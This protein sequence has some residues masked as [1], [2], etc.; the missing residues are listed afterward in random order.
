MAT[1]LTFITSIWS[2]LEPTLLLVQLGFQF[3]TKRHLRV[4]YSNLEPFV[5]KA[6]INTKNHIAHF[7]IDVDKAVPADFD[8]YLKHIKS[9]LKTDRE[10]FIYFD[11]EIE[12]RLLKK[13]RISNENRF[14]KFIQKSYLYLNGFHNLFKAHLVKEKLIKFFR[15]GKSFYHYISI[16]DW[17]NKSEKELKKEIKEI[18]KALPLWNERYN[19]KRVNLF[20]DSNTAINKALD[21]ALKSGKITEQTILNLASSEKI[22][23][24][25]KYAEGF[26]NVYNL[27]YEKRQLIIE[28]IKKNKQRESQAAKNR[29][30]I[31]QKKLDKINEEWLISPINYALEKIGFKKMFAKSPHI[32]ILP[33]SQIPELYQKNPNSFI[34]NVVI[35]EADNYL[36]GIKESSDLLADFEGGLKYLIIAHT[37]PINEM[38]FYAKE[39]SLEISSKTLAKMLLSSFLQNEDENITSIYINDIV[40][41]VDF[42]SQ[43]SANTKTGKYLLNNYEQL[44]QIL[45]NKHQIDIQKPI[46]LITL[47]EQ[48]INDIVSELNGINEYSRPKL[49]VKMLTERIDFYKELNKELNEIKVKK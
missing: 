46:T 25:H 3:K 7:K 23:L 37:V 19:I 42:K 36:K 15:R 18:K 21:K 39:R 30:P 44:K 13:Y 9:E 47:S 43:L 24:I 41:N 20:D 16:N 5:K 6:F 45:W 31:L 8:V 49:I 29:L 17:A 35:P 28:Q 10:F 40:R 33:L 4:N 12:Y 11:G 34:E 27:Q 32:F 38:R 22:V 14:N 48:N 2:W 26:S 1:I